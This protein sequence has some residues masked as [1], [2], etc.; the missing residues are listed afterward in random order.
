MAHV[1]VL[2]GDIGVR[3]AGTNGERR[4]AEYIRDQLASYGYDTRLQEF[5]ISTYDE[6]NASVDLISPETRPIQAASI[7]GSVSGTAEGELVFGGVGKPEDFPSSTPG[8]IALLERGDVF[9]GQKSRNAAEAGA[10]AI[11]VYNNVPGNFRGQTN[12]D[13]PVPAVSVSQE[14]GQALRQLVESGP[15]TVRVSVEGRKV[16]GTSRN[17]IAVPPGGACRVIA[18]GH[19]DSVLAGPGANDN[20]SGT[21]VVIEMARALAADGTPPDVCF[22][23]FGSE[24]IGLLG[25]AHYVETITA[26]ERAQILGML[27][28]DML[29][30]GD[31][32]PL[33]GDTSLVYLAGEVAED[34]GVPYSISNDRPVGSDHASFSNAD[35]SSVMFNCFCDPN[36]HTAADVPEYLSVDRIQT[37]GDLG[38]RLV[39]ELLGEAEPGAPSR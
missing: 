24:E 29:G 4:A 11:V 30:V 34:L 21:S 37:A 12:I 33:E 6:I 8:R 36:Y 3:A 9:F 26:D 18:G 14:D 28:F 19:L 10:T 39:Q 22:T 25:S 16:S 17:V 1:S 23:L 2:A 38:L 13:T 15:V 31:L 5:P 7:A 35:I 32:W 20:A 27:N